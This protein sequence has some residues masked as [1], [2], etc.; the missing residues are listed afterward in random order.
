M[1]VVIELVLALRV[2]PLRSLLLI[3]L[4]RGAHRHCLRA[5][6]CTVGRENSRS[7]SALSQAGQDGF[8]LPRMRASN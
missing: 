7:N 6:E 4:L 1:I 5:G 2:H 3:T 8:S